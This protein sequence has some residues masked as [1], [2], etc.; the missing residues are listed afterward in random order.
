[1]ADLARR[2]WT[3]LLAEHKHQA[4]RGTTNYDARAKEFICAAFLDIASL[5]YHP[6]LTTV[7]SDLTLNAGVQTLAVPTDLLIPVALQLHNSVSPGVPIGELRSVSP[8]T[9]LGLQPPTRRPNQWCWFAGNFYFNSLADV[10][11]KVRPFYQKRPVGPDFTAG[12]FSALAREWDER[13]LE[14]SVVYAVTG[15]GAAMN[16]APFMDL[17]RTWT[18]AATQPPLQVNPIHPYFTSQDRQQ[19]PLGGPHG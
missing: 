16:G 4:R 7:G 12:K 3:A 2:D 18:G 14:L 6:E 17:F 1:M 19:G 5:F 9:L 10:A 13:I 8:Q 11:Y 15:N